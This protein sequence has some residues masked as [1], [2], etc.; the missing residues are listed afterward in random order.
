MNNKT[1]EAILEKARIALQKSVVTRD[2]QRRIYDERRKKI[3]PKH[4]IEV[5]ILSYNDF[6]FDSKKG[7]C[8]ILKKI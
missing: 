3:L 7:L 6:N 4:G 8:A 5:A 2:I 1:V